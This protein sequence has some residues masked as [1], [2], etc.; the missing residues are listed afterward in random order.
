M[1]LVLSGE[2]DIASTPYLA[3]RLAEHLEQGGDLM[4]EAGDLSFIDVSG[5]RALVWAAEQLGDGRR[6][7]VGSASWVLERALGQ[8]GW[9]DHPQL[10]LLSREA[11]LS[12]PA[13][14]M[15]AATTHRAC[16]EG[17][18]HEA[19]FYA[20]H[21]QFMDGTLPFIREAV[22]AD[23][24]IL[25]VL[26]GAKINALRHELGGDG[27]Q[28][29]F[30]DMAEVGANPARIIPAWED[31]VEQHVAPGRRLWG[32]GEPI[33]AT[34][35]PAELAECQRHE[36]L[37][38]VVFSSS[39]FSLLCPYDTDALDQAV[40]DEA[41]RNHPFVR[42]DDIPMPSMHFPG[43]E[44]FATPF[45]DPLSDP[46][47]G[48]PVVAFQ[49]TTLREVRGLVAAQAARAGL[50]SE[51][52]ED[53]LLAVN[54]VATNS[55]V[56]GGGRGTVGVWQEADAVICEVRDK[57]RIEDPLIGR[58]RPL[59]ESLGGRGLWLANQ[60]C[61]LVQVRTFPAGNVVRLHMRVTDAVRS[62]SA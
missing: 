9:A 2:I 25:V 14:G 44:F 46:P 23:E 34:R 36:A 20:G 8:C 27:G 43:S 61:E 48:A 11:D 6:L 59:A 39:A 56:H 12:R 16:R 55:L 37:L 47:H 17:Y 51:R 3:A 26:D 41:R 35:S 45:D 15:S 50:P 5:C 19:F 42:E 40:I 60:L 18:R 32:I 13:G 33:W 29:L 7:V 57:G 62:P 54:E 53:L 22:A 31:F 28:V 49:V 30:A 38:N 21:G 10:V 1:A 24:P 4:V 58:R 52:I